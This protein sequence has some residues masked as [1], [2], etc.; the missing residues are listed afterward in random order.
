MLI[1]RAIMYGIFAVFIPIMS[2]VCLFGGAYLWYFDIGGTIFPEKTN[3]VF[4]I[5]CVLFLVSCFT[6]E[7]FKDN[8]NT[9]TYKSGSTGAS[10]GFFAGS[11]DGGGSG[12][13]C[14]GGDGGGC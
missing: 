3:L 13:S 1:L 14:G 8:T 4:I 9:G 10:S 6:L 7:L 5:G 12:G 2:V 11:G